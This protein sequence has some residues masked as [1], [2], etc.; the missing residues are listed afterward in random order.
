[1]LMKDI[2][3]FSIKLILTPVLIVIAVGVLALY[4]LIGAVIVPIQSLRYLGL[5]TIAA[6]R[7]AFTNKDYTNIFLD[8]LYEFLKRYL[9]FYGQIFF[10]PLA[11]WMPAQH[12]PSDLSKILEYQWEVISANWLSTIIVFMTL[13]F[14]FTLSFS[15][16]G[17]RGLDYLHLYELKEKIFSNNSTGTSD[18]KVT[19]NDDT[20]GGENTIAT[21]AMLLE[22]IDSL[23]SIIKNEIPALKKENEILKENAGNGQVVYVDKPVY[24]EKVVFKDKPVIQEKIVYQDKP[25]YQEKVVYKEKPEPYHPYGKGMAQLSIYTQCRIGITDVLVDGEKCGQ[26]NC[27]FTSNPGC[28]AN[29]CTVAKTV[30]SGK[31]HIEA[32]NLST[33]GSWDFYVT[34][35]EDECLSQGLRCE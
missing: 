20:L 22:R 32:K 12:N 34:L 7:S 21:E 6:V 29:S 16:L 30:L 10:I 25:I 5:T 8:A 4:T 26:L 11:I 3:K 33:R 9:A 17:M 15:M 27:Y 14:S 31:H 13:I 1:M 2:F 19:Q 18:Y 23:N 35:K 24:Q 28:N